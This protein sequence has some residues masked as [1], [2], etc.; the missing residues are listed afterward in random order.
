MFVYDLYSIYLIKPLIFSL[1]Y[2]IF[3]FFFLFQTPAAVQFIEQAD[4][5]NIIKC[6]HVVWLLP[7]CIISAFTEVIYLKEFLSKWFL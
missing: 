4:E 2:K 7:W 1:Y 6:R 5:N 3:V